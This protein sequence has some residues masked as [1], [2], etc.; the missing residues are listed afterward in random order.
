MR[1]DVSFA[2]RYLFSMTCIGYRV[3]VT[4]RRVRD[5][6]EGDI[7][8]LLVGFVRPDASSHKHGASQLQQ[9]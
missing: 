2:A 7:E 3:A 1:P 9:E 5:H 4:L 6:V 8:L